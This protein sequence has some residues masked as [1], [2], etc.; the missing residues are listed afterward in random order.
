MGVKL[1]PSRP[2][3]CS[4]PH[5]HTQPRPCGHLPRHRCAVLSCPSHDSQ[6][7]DEEPVAVP[8]GLWLPSAP[9][10]TPHPSPAVC[11]CVCTRPHLTLMAPRRRLPCASFQDMSAKSELTLVLCWWRGVSEMAGLL[12]SQEMPRPERAG[13]EEGPQGLWVHMHLT[14]LP[15]MTLKNAACR[16]VS[17]TGRPFNSTSFH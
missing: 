3:P 14:H 1:R 16:N 7:G 6:V 17:G 8:Q 13:D 12:F 2:H 5:P 10:V 11:H 15:G 4:L 9:G